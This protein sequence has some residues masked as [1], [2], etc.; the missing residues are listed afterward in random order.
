[1]NNSFT[2]YRNERSGSVAHLINCG[3]LCNDTNFVD[4]VS[5]GGGGGAIYIDNSF[6]IENNA[7]FK[8]CSFTRC[9]ALYGGAIFVSAQSQ[10]FSIIVRGCLFS[11]NEVTLKNP[12]NNKNLFG[13]QAL[14]VMSNNFDVS[15]TTFSLNKG[16]G[17]A[18][19]IYSNIEAKS[20]IIQSE[21]NIKESSILFI[22]CIFEQLED[23]KSSIDYV[24]SKS[25]NRI[26][27]VDC[28]FKG[29]L[30]KELILSMD[31][32]MINSQ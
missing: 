21:A 29:K 25:S 23:S 17:G 32:C 26:E 12:S 4:C 14:Y 20:L 28:I 19:K 6:D 2:G 11:S 13:G 24:E 10:E 3:L 1:M 9:K 27:I 5:S 30:K 22:G 16:K 15:N 18:V 7:T 31:L 8:Y